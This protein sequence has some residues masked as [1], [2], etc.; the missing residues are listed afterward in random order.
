MAPDGG[1]FKVTKGAAD[2]VLSIIDVNKDIV[3]SSV[4][5]KVC[6]WQSNLGNAALSLALLMGSPGQ[7][8]VAQ[9]CYL[10]LEWLAYHEMLLVRSDPA[11]IT[12]CGVRQVQE[13][14][15]R[16]IR[17]MAVARTDGQGRWHM[18]GLLTFLDPP[19]PDT[20][21][22]LQTAL[23]YGVQTRMVTTP[24]LPRAF[25]KGIC[26]ERCSRAE[27]IQSNVTCAYRPVMRSILKQSMRGSAQGQ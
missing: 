18:L 24:S 16:G 23:R 26:S 13:Y 25:P 21:S 5:Q 15:H 8:M 10:S 17:C 22:T 4:N 27:T 2:A 3:A 12:V 11:A 1:T 9:T 19:R 6:P 20:R 14:G 7:V